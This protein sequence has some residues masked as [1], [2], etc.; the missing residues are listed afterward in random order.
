MRISASAA[1]LLF[2]ICIPCNLIYHNIIIYNHLSL[3]L[4]PLSRMNDIKKINRALVSV[5]DKTGLEP[6]IRAMHQ[7]SIEI[8]STGGT[9]KF[10][11]QLGMPV[12][13]VSSLTGFP[14]IF[15]GRV[16]TLHPFVFGGILQRSDDAKDKKE[17]DQHN[18][19]PIDLVVVDLYPFEKTITAKNSG[20]QS[21]TEQEVIE[22]IDIGGV[23]LI[24]A[25]AKNFNDVLII[26]SVDDYALLKQVLEQNASTDLA[27]RK[28][29][30]AR[31]F[32]ITAHY[33]SLIQ[34][35]FDDQHSVFAEV[36][37]H[38]Q[39]L[40]YGENPH[41]QGAYFGRLNEVF[42]Q[43]NGKELSYNNLLDVDAALSLISEFDEC[44][45]AI[46]KH[47]IACGLASAK[48]TTEAWSR[49]LAADP[50]SAFG[51]IIAFNRQVDAMVAN[52]I[53]KLFFE[54]LIAPSYH[55]DA[56]A[57][58]AQKKNRILLRLINYPESKF[59]FQSSL[60]GILFQD[61]DVKHETKEDLKTVTEQSPSASQTDDLLFALR[62]V[63]HTRSNAIVLAKNKQLLASGT[64]QT[65]RVDAL[66]QAIEKAK[67]FN[68]DLNN[69]V[70]ASDAFF[71]FP[72][73]VEIAAAA[74]ITAIAQPGGSVKDK[75]SVEACNRLKIAMV[76]TGF[77]HFRH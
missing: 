24:R 29:M 3:H 77:R 70:M 5:F 40:R 45:C 58:L 50:V 25:A 72:D 20:N 16:K 21:V 63:K 32:A 57:L 51:G 33:D 67:R 6:L 73:C 13:E 68:M 43:L 12:T 49:A 71:P 48:S 7:N 23:S 60:N 41:Q 53:N 22:K 28:Q 59:R 10:I 64:G 14:E 44:T 65:S 36:N 61:K 55:P 27:L 75:E 18:I 8:I 52:E 2:N 37:L 9:K 62:I 11:E 69:S 31:A 34:R 38:K 4:L 39:T 74:D 26:P 47:N 19:P 76:M 66:N 35:Y 1:F 56:L 17:A 15:G 46:I 54:I 30:A 42:E